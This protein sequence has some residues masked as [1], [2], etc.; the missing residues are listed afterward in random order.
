MLLRFEGFLFGG[1]LNC[2]DL[3]CTIDV[4]FEGRQVYSKN[5]DL[6]HQCLDFIAPWEAYIISALMFGMEHSGRD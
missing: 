6:R 1:D 3:S 5:F 4:V 2:G